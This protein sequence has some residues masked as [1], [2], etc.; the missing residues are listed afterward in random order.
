MCMQ[1]F[2]DEADLFAEQRVKDE[3]RVTKRKADEMSMTGTPADGCLEGRANNGATLN[4][5]VIPQFARG[6]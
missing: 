3:E 5:V 6:V 4:G 2:R 1:I